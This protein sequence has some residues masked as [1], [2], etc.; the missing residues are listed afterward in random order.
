MASHHSN[1]LSFR[2]DDAGRTA[3][4]L[5]GRAIRRTTGESISTSDVIRLAVN[6]GLGDL[7][8]LVAAVVSRG[9]K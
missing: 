8:K 5:A 4:N 3:I 6:L 1:I 2:V 7:E 9:C